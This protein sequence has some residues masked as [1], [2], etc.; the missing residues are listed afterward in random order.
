MSLSY[1]DY[2]YAQWLYQYLL[3]D[4][5]NDYG[6]AGLMGNLYAE[7][8][9]CPFRQQGMNYANSWTLTETFRQNNKNYFVYYDGN[10]GYSLAQWTTYS[11]RSN[12]WDYIGG[13]SY[14][15]DN[16]KS[17]E[18]LLYELQTGYSSVYNSLVN[19]T[20]IRGASDTVL[21]NYEAPQDQSQAVKD[22]RAYYSSEVYNDFSGLPPIPP[23]TGIDIL[24]L[25][26]FFI[27]RQ[28]RK[29]I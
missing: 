2:S 17:A 14:V 27:D 20:S 18:F 23:G 8:G 15:G 5:G 7:S 16:T 3:A 9:I 28:F 6:V 19:A 11:R 21:V 26:K 10:T 22:L 13:A 1:W 12:Y 29:M 4:I 25:K 24:F